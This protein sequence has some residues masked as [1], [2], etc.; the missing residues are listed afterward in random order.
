MPK[1]TPEQK[2]R[3]AAE[4]LGKAAKLQQSS[5][6]IRVVE[7]MNKDPDL[8]SPIYEYAERLVSGGGGV[9]SPG[10]AGAHI[11]LTDLAP[12]GSPAKLALQDAGPK[13]APTPPTAKAG[14]RNAPKASLD[15]LLQRPI[16][17]QSYRIELLPVLDLKN[18]LYNLNGQTFTEWTLRSL[19]RLGQRHVSRTALCELVEFLTG[20]PGNSSLSNTYWPRVLDFAT[21]LKSLARQYGDRCTKVRMPPNWTDYIQGDGIYLMDLEGV[22]GLS[23]THRFADKHIRFSRE[24]LGWPETGAVHIDLNFS[25]S[26]AKLRCEGCVRTKN[27]ANLFLENGV[28]TR[29]L[30]LLSGPQHSYMTPTKRP[31]TASGS[32]AGGSTKKPRSSDGE[33]ACDLREDDVV[34]EPAG[35]EGSRS[36][37]SMGRPASEAGAPS[38]VGEPE[39]VLEESYQPKAPEE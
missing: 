21:H 19:L 25:D 5:M 10:A 30:A 32:S 38:S 35:L 20:V 13:Q 15:T 3:R 12:N 27:C 4:L 16:D 29:P 24:E 39:A 8:A 6:A 2:A 26:R 7:V 18:L 1:Q 23:L 31:K 22:G 37:S 17:R 14:G 34:S 28:D 33:P 11:A 36:A 9:P